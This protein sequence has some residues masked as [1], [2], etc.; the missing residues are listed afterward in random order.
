MQGGRE[1]HRNYYDMKFKYKEHSTSI[2]NE[3]GL[4]THGYFSE[5]FKGEVS[6]DK[7]KQR[8]LLNETMKI[9][10][11]NAY[12]SSFE[13]SAEADE[14]AAQTFSDKALSAHRIKMKGVKA[15]FLTRKDFL[16]KKNGVKE[17][18]KANLQKLSTN[19]MSRLS[20]SPDE[21]NSFS[22]EVKGIS[23]GMEQAPP[24]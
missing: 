20:D 14:A 15:S 5:Q 23:L 7:T 13:P 22:C 2:F 4:K 17:K 11:N 19:S 10:Q 6:R 21:L 12:P 3:E 24:K 16:S 8:R 9:I 1:V 18:F